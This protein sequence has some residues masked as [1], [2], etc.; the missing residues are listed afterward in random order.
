M[1]IIIDVILI[2]FKTRNIAETRQKKKRG[3]QPANGTKFA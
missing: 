2:N 3:G 1:D